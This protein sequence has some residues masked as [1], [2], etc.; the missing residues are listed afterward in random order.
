MLPECRTP[1]PSFAIPTFDVTP[2]DVGLLLDSRDVDVTRASN[3]IFASRHL[4][5]GP[6]LQGP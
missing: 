2:S 3:A 5:E 1:G 4:L 6:I